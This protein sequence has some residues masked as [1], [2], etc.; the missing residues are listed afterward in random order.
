MIQKSKKDSY[1]VVGAHDNFGMTI[2]NCLRSSV[3]EV[4]SL[5]QYPSGRKTDQGVNAPFN[6]KEDFDNWFNYD[7][8][9][10]QN[11]PLAVNEMVP[12]LVMFDGLVF[13]GKHVDGKDPVLVNA[14]DIS[15]HFMANVINPLMLLKYMEDFEL[16]V[17]NALAV[18]LWERRYT[19]PIHLSL[20]LSSAALAE[21]AHMF[22]E[23]LKLK[24]R[25]VFVVPPSAAI[26][27]SDDIVSSQILRLLG[28][29]QL[30]SG[31]TVDLR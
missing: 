16:M 26:A 20:E 7:M 22:F 9:E 28:D 21:T 19:E 24:T 25:F 18:F 6:P 15:E 31:T 13:A 10:P 30:Q 17:S 3:H 11:V 29:S 8:V 5:Q 27:G 4:F 14:L 1:L 12:K 23:K 2:S